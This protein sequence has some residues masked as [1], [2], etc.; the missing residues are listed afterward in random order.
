[1]RRG[2]LTYDEVWHA[3]RENCRHVLASVA[4]LLRN[5]DAET[6]VI[7]ADHANAFGKRGYTGTPKA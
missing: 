6:A 7:T 3:Y 1:L 5:Y 2:K 4:V